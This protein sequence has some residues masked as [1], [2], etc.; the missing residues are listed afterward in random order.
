MKILITGACGF[1]GRNLVKYLAAFGEELLLTDLPPLLFDEDVPAEGWWMD[2]KI[3]HCDIDRDLA[4]LTQYINDIDTVFHLAS[5]TRIPPSWVDYEEYYQTNISSTQR[6]FELCQLKGVKRFIYVSSSSVYGNN[7]TDP[8]TEDSPLM[9]TNPY[10]VSKM[11]AEWALR[12]QASQGDTEL[13]IVRPFTM[14]GDWMDQGPNGLV[15]SKFITALERNEPLT[16]H[17]DGEQRRDFLHSS[18]AV[19][20][21]KLIMDYGRPGEVYNLGSGV[22][23]SVNELADIVGQATVRTPDRPGAVR[24]T[25]ANV[26]K[27]KALGYMPQVSVTQWLTDKVKETKLRKLN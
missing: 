22:A 18:D 4:G 5:K 7:N 25:N 26:D 24:V 3:I 8:Q 17:G 14:Y 11:A 27:L 1:L 16:I 10:A 23:V 13:I 9:P 6:F 20:G 19:H 12:V 2:Q 15:V 21:L